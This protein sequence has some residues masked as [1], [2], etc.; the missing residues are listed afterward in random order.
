MIV[1]LTATPVYGRNSG[2]RLCSTPRWQSERSRASRSISYIRPGFVWE[3]QQ[4]REHFT[5]AVFKQLG[6]KMPVFITGESE[7]SGL[8]HS[9]QWNYSWT[10][11]CIIDERDMIQPVLK[12]WPRQ[13]SGMFLSLVIKY[14]KS[15]IS[16]TFQQMQYHR[17]LDCGLRSQSLMNWDLNILQYFTD[18]RYTVFN[19]S[20][21]RHLVC[22]SKRVL[23]FYLVHA[24]P[25]SN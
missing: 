10:L 20:Y 6:S 22:E 16:H 25:T 12:F 1:S 15:S 11:D 21:Y 18:V 19:M 7:R 5:A 17:K 8:L 2:F 13:M 9:E 23:F 14:A 4:W 24:P 3:A